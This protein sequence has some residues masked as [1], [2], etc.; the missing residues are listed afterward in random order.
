MIFL[1]H[2]D[3]SRQTLLG[4]GKVYVQRNSKVSDLFS[5]INEKMRWP[6]GTPLKLYEVWRSFTR[7]D[8]NDECFGSLQMVA[9]LRKSNLA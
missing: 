8:F 1:K 9:L 4:V 2:F 7:G 6:A 5:Y 3:T